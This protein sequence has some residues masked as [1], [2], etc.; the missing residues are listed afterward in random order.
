[1]I[2]KIEH[3]KNNKFAIKVNEEEKY[4][5][6]R[7]WTNMNLPSKDTYIITTKDEKLLYYVKKIKINQYEFIDINNEVKCKL[8]SNT[9]EFENHEF[10]CYEKAT[11]IIENISIFD[12]DKQIAQIIFP[13]HSGR[14]YFFLL[15]E[16]KNL[17]SVIAL[18][19]VIGEC[20]MLWAGG[21]SFGFF[22]IGFKYTYSKDDVKYYN[23]NWISNNFDKVKVDNIYDEI[24]IDRQEAKADYLKYCKKVL[25]FIGLGL[26][27]LLVFVVIV[28]LLLK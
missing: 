15:D 1:M 12:N 22:P 14:R 27:F 23:E 16:Y 3:I 21:H 7:N 2:I 6:G 24:K 11:G 8:D 25:S 13:Q 9:I 20:F 4:L 19:A 10:I 17:D 18:S 5:A 26:V 28:I